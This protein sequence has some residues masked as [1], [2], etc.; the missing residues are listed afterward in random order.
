[1]TGLRL[2]T[3]GSGRLI[4]ELL[5]QLPQTPH[6]LVAAVVHSPDRA[7]AD[8][9]ELTVGAAIGVRTTT[10]LE[11]ALQ[12]GDV[13]VLLYGGLVGEIHE[14]AMRCCATAG[15]DLVH[16]CFV[17]PDVALGRLASGQLAAAARASGARILGTGVLPG[18]WLDVLPALLATCLP[19]AVRISGRRVSNLSSWGAGVLRHELG[20]GEPPRGPAARYDAVLR[21]SAQELVDA[22]EIEDATVSSEGGVVL[23]SSAVQVGGIDVAT[24]HVVGFDQRVVVHAAGEQVIELSW[25]ALPDPEAQSLRPGLELTLVGGDG[26]PLTVHAISPPDPYPGTV[27]RMIKSIGPLRR[28]PPGLHLPAALAVT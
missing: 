10:D 20:L 3:Y 8:L 13:D 25:I 19:D 21:E 7:G 15:I 16:T 11:Q 1:V 18:M 14:H 4:A 2:A 28:L 17:H 12:H 6:S 24:G 23:A 9:G 27:A 5:R 22:L 26:A